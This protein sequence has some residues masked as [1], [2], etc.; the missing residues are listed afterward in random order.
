[1]RPAKAPL[2]AR[3]RKPEKADL[4]GLRAVAS[5]SFR[6]RGGRY[7]PRE[8]LR[9]SALALRGGADAIAIV[10]GVDA[11]GGAVRVRVLT[12]GELSSEDVE[13]A[14]DVARGLAA[15]DDDPTEFLAMVRGHPV[16]GPLSRR[17]DPRLPKSPTVFESL[18]IAV[19][20]QLVTGFEAR[21]SIRRLW[22]LAGAP[23]AGT[24]LVAA[25]TAA[26]VGRVPMWQ[27]HALGIGSRR[28]VTLHRAAGRGNAIERLR[29]HE[30]Q[31]ALAKL[32]S[33][34]GVGPWTSNAVARSA[35]GW[36]DAVPLGDYHAPFFIPP[37]LGGT[38]DL[39]RDDPAG[40]DAAMLEALAPFRPHRAR[41]VMLLE[42]AAIGARER[43]LPRVDP[44]RR[45][46]WRY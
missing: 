4:S 2:F 19:V 1:V 30:P 43:R 23:I 25:P 27:M 40:A 11:S 24:S 18:A 10:F 3:A 28:A 31:G 13:R 6:P 16:L 41:A 45:E 32:E 44:H 39:T 36:A 17:A 12:N 37:A 35:F 38:E 29:D 33:L 14:L 34:P 42:G 21:A 15:V 26:A 22:R 9:R 5:A 7:D 46:P 8:H 20:E